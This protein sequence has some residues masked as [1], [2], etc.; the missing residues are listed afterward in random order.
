MTDISALEAYAGQLA[1]AAELAT[2]SAQTQ[3]AVVNGDASTDVLTESGLVPTLA[4]QAVLSQAKV[5]ASLTEVASQMAGAMTYPSIALGLAGTV[6]GGYFSVPSPDADEYLILYENVA[7]VAAER[8]RY[9][10]ADGILN[11][12][13]KTGSRDVLRVLDRVGKSALRITRSGGFIVLG[14]D[15]F[16]E[17]GVA[18]GVAKNVLFS[19]SA[20]GGAIAFG[21]SHG[22]APIKLTR[23]GRV[24]IWGRDVLRELDALGD[25]AA[26][27]AKLDSIN[28]MLT[29]NKNLIVAGDSLSA[30]ADSWVRTLIPALTDQSRTLT[31]LAVGGQ[32][33]SQQ[34]GRLGALPFLLTLQNNKIL[35]S[36]ATTVSA[37]QMLAPD[38]VTLVNVW[39]IS[40]QGTGPTWRARVSGVLGTFSSATF[41]GE[42]PTALVFTPDAGQLSAD[43]PVEVGVPTESA[44]AAGHEYDTLLIAM[45]RNNFQDTATVKRDWLAVRNWQRTLNKRCVMVTPPNMSGEGIVSGPAKYAAIVELE[46]YAQELFGEYVVV[47]R[48]VLMRHPDTSLTADVDAV[49]DGRVPPS[50]TSDGL[51]WLPATGHAYIRAA[52]A[53]IIN[54]KGY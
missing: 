30:Y 18:L 5:T 39:P 44:W 46:R 24:K 52:A 15:I 7:G 36:G 3:H 9:P 28:Q 33:S 54:R 32:T 43:L 48:Q 4:K 16:A 47:S 35:A 11:L 40:S 12:I 17:L 22:K 13:R 31:N 26:F 34:A 53:A 27:A 19:G 1:E 42:V 45:G 49:A 10:S 14:R 41:T 6:K 23:T 8:K 37:S 21:D 25:G 51:H 38:G 20:R 29:P 2:S 50:L